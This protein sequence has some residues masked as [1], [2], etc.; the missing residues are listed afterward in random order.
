MPISRRFVVKAKTKLQKTK[1]G[2]KAI[3]TDYKMNFIGVFSTLIFADFIRFH[4]I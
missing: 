1:I 3:S 2:H 4:V